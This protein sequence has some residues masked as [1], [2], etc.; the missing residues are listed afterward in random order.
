MYF[1]INNESPGPISAIYDCIITQSSRNTKY[2]LKFPFAPTPPLFT[3]FPV[4]LYFVPS[5][6]EK[7]V[8]A[9]S[10]DIAT[11]TYRPD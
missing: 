9:I 4:V 10:L 2:P 8:V 6:T 3:T 7:Q 5:H 11:Y 1:Y